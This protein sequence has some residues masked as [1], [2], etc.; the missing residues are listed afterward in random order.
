[1]DF[2]TIGLDEIVSSIAMRDMVRFPERPS[3][4]T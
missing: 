1:M 4:Y 3:L 2:D